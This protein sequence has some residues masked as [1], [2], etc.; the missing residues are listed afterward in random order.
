MESTGSS[1]TSG[2]FHQTIRV[3]FQKTELFLLC[4]LL[5]DFLTLVFCVKSLNLAKHSIVNNILTWI[6]I[7]GGTVLS[8]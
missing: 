6:I 3:I 8:P 5:Q 2:G 7:V 4:F 1:E